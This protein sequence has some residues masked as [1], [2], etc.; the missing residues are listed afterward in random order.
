MP[1]NRGPRLGVGMLLCIFDRQMLTSSWPTVVE[2]AVFRI[3]DGLALIKFII[4]VV[5]GRC[6]ARVLCIDLNGHRNGPVV[7]PGSSSYE[8]V[9]ASIVPLAFCGHHFSGAPG[10]VRPGQVLSASAI[11]K[12]A[13]EW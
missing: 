13:L 2:K 11:V 1:Y 7:I 4:I 12:A 6:K 3:G 5:A 9:L 8:L 10:Y